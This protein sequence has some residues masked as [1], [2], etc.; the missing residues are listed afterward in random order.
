MKFTCSCEDSNGDNLCVADE[1][2]DED[3]E[4]DLWIDE[5]CQEAEEEEEVESS[6][7]SF[8]L[9]LLVALSLSYLRL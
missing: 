4:C 3:A 2:E 1:D 6:A 9:G 5:V 8:T 7:G